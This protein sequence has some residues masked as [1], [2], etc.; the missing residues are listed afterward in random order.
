MEENR[1]RRRK[2]RKRRIWPW[3][4]GPIVLILVAVGVYVAMVY[5]DLT[6]TLDTVHEPIEREASE[7]REKPVSLN[8]QEPFSTL[9]LGVDEREGDRGRSDTMIVLTVNPKEQTTKMVSI[10]RDTYT[11]IVGRGTQDKLNHAYAFGGIEMAM[12]STENLLDIPIDYVVQVNMESFQDIVDAVGGVTVQ[13]N[14]SFKSGQYTFP[15]GPVELNGEE[16]LAYV[17]MRK[18][19]PNGDFGRQDRQK[20]VI[21]GVL[22]EGASANSILNY[23]SIFG[24]IGKNIRTNMTLDEMLGLQDY[25]GAIG[26]VDQL[27]FEKGQGQRIDGIWYYMMNEEELNAVSSELKQHLEI[28]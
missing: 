5:K 22:R 10:P 6:D 27:Y 23:Q 19:D 4:V 18:Q 12:D 16:A 7:K 11:E 20:D 9:V 17:Q 3:I 2:K 21:M 28:E 15:E 24:A 14:M 25:R 13:N 8:D 1:K 26:Q